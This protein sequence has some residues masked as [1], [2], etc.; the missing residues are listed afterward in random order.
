MSPE[1]PETI[2]LAGLGLL[3]SALAARLREA[4]YGVQGYDIDEATRVA[5]REQ[6]VTVAAGLEELSRCGTILLSLPSSREVNEV[7]DVLRPVLAPAT[8]VIDTTTG[9]PTETALIGEELSGYGIDYMDA[10]VAGSSVQV[11]EGRGVILAGGAAKTIAGCDEILHALAPT[12]LHVG[13]C[14]SGARMKLVVNLVLGLNRVVLAEGLAFAERM[15]LDPRQALDALRATPAYSAAMDA[16]GEKMV[17]RDFEPQ[18]RLRQHLKDVRLMLSAARRAGAA[19][20]LTRQ[21]EALLAQLVEAGHGE[22]DNSAI[23][24]AFVDPDEG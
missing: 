21:H 11:R 13:P 24:R 2:G 22:E 12:V 7:V 20:P 18:A 17:Q 23:L 16:K 5:A 4:G 10:T 3:G 19:L 8:R 15:G 1:Q 9:D 6:G 14:G